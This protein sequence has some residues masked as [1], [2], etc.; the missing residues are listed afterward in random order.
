MASAGLLQ[1]Q[2]T[3]SWFCSTVL[4]QSRWYTASMLARVLLSVCV[5]VCVCGGG[6][7]EILHHEGR[8]AGGVPQRADGGDVKDVDGVELQVVQL[9]EPQ[10]R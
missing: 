9:A 2:A 8:Q 4:R 7:T 10:L 5:C 1:S 3:G 6:L